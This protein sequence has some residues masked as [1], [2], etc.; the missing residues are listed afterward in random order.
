MLV[1]GSFLLLIGLIIALD[2]GVFHRKA[3]VVSL[4][5]ALGWTTAWITLALTFNV[6][7]Y[8]L[9]ELNPS[10]WDVDTAQLTGAE[11]ALQFFTGYIVEKSLSID[12]I[13]VIAMVFAYFRVPLAEQHR[14]LFWGI[15]GALVLRG[16]MIGLGVVLIA[17]FS[18]I[19][20]LFGGLLIY[21][22]ARMMV[23]RHDSLDP[24]A[25]LFVRA[26]KHIHPVTTEFH[27]SRFF[28]TQDG[29]RMATPLFL[30][31]LMV[32]A[33]DVTF[34]IDSIPAIF[35]ITKDPFIVFTSNV[36]A[37]LGLRSLYF[38]LAG[39][40]E[41]FRYLK[42]S[43]VFLL[44]YIG[45][46]MLL[47]HHH[48]IPNEIS[49]AVIG[50]ILA[51]GVLASIVVRKDPVH[52]VSPLASEM[53]RLVRVSYRQ[54]RKAVILV[55]GSS[56]LAVGIAMLVLPGPAFVVIPAGLAVLALEFAWAR[57]WLGRV[58]R[59]LADV[60]DKLRNKQPP[61]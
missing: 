42:M 33:S 51:T 5:E 22:A 2:L 32:E 55:I 30:A 16:L 38:V 52:L 41:K 7:I 24:D 60:R 40:M 29:V 1:W 49:L 11:A 9:Y 14:V 48:P 46:K 20:Y 25:N 37:V 8:Y 13:F 44:A 59:E 34:A 26:F 21:S 50:G 3:R 15:F 27:G 23:I 31:L 61:A 28:V 57:R 17:K 18:W 56:I 58:K 10:G 36:F 45:V 39:L 4:P 54:A 47:V 43:L 6:G 12:N 35:A 19:T 53:E